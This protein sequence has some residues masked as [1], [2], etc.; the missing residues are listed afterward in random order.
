[1]AAYLG[2]N[3]QARYVGDVGDFVKFAT[4]RALAPGHQVGVAWWL[5]PDESHNDDGRHIDYLQKPQIWRGFDAALFDRLKDIVASGRRDLAALQ[6]A[7]LMPGAIF[8]NEVFPAQTPLPDRIGARR[9]WFNAVQK[10]LGDADLVFVDPD[11]GLEPDTFRPGSHTAGKSVQVS[12][13]LE[14]SRPGRTLV[15]YHHQ[16]RRKGG[17]LAEIEYWADRLRQTGF[18]SVD[19]IR[20]KPYS[21]RVFFILNGS[22]TIQKRAEGLTDIWGEFLSWHPDSRRSPAR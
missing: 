8:S 19:A 12:E 17:H 10:D 6:D 21:P 5:Y 20:A 13:L 2:E 11:N 7:G 9:R 1:M 18:A 14:L 15:V 22:Q 4:L 3:K 16:T